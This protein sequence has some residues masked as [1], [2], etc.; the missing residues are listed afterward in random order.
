VAEGGGDRTV[1]VTVPAAD[2]DL[3]T[4]RLWQAG[5][6]A[7]AERAVPGAVVLGAGGDPGSL[8]AAVAGRWP[9]ET[10]VVD[11]AAALDAWRP[12]ARAVTVG[13]RLVVRPPWV[14]PQVAPGA[15][16][17]IVD[18]GRAFGSGAHPSTR[19]A[20]AALVQL[21]QGGERV[22]DVGCGSGVLALAALALG[23]A[24]AVGV[25]IDPAARAA[26]TANAARNGMGARLAVT[27]TIARAAGPTGGRYP[28]VVANLLLPDLV[29]LAPEIA[30]AVHEHGAL[31]VSGV[32]EGQRAEVEQAFAG[33]G[34]V[35]A[36]GA[37]GWLALTLRVP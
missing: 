10:V 33:A 22:L 8:L 1:R 12:Y 27:D 17:V 30:T 25:D 2:A 20:L 29:S 35:A 21:V 16:E 36:A 28:L 34:V 23:A 18:P 6:S 9:A 5:A 3:A 37:D 11:L 13:D 7:I 14:A 32:L 15:V 19:L 24:E 26:T 4:D 31:V